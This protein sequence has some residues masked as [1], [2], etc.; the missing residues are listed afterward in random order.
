METHSKGR[1]ERA[2]ERTGSTEKQQHRCD[3]H[4]SFPLIHVYYSPARLYGLFRWWFLST[5]LRDMSFS[6]ALQLNFAYVSATGTAVLCRQPAFL[7]R[8]RTTLRS[9]FVPVAHRSGH[10][11]RPYMALEGLGPVEHCLARLHLLRK[12]YFGH[13]ARFVVR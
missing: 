9:A 8:V 13:V 4:L 10:T 1:Q 6:M 5:A 12:I 2:V 3:Q 11:G 7:D